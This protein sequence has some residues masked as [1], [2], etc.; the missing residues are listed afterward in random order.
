MPKVFFPAIPT[1][2]RLAFVPITIFSVRA[3]PFLF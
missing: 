3:P 2:E 1:G